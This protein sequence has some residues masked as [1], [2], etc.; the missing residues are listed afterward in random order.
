M[1]IMDVLLKQRKGYNILVL[2][3]MYISDEYKVADR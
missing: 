1:A 3:N 2:T